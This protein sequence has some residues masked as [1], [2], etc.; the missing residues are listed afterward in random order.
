MKKSILL[1]WNNFNLSKLIRCLFLSLLF[2]SFSAFG[3]SSADGDD[4]RLEAEARAQLRQLYFHGLLR[5]IPTQVP[6]LAPPCQIFVLYHKDDRAHTAEVEKFCERM[7]LA[8]IDFSKILFEPW[9]HRPGCGP[10]LFHLIL[11]KLC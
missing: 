3:T 7:L 9:A 4:A 5:Q 6:A 2:S 10:D 1:F 8:G 11:G